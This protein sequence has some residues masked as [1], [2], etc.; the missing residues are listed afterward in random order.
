MLQGLHLA[1]PPFLSSLHDTRLKPTHV[2]MHGAPV[3]G[4]PVQSG[5]RSRTDRRFRR[6]LL[7]FF[8]RLVK[9]SRDGRP[10]GSLPA[11]APGDVARRLNPYPP[12]YRA[13]FACSLFLYPHRRRRALQPSYPER[14][15]TGLPCST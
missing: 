14:S 3:G 8:G 12:R 11:F 1:P 5:V 9:L 7:C 10:E 6:H 13:A 15:D 4:V 2:L